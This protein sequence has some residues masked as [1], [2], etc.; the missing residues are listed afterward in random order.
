MKFYFKNDN[1]VDSDNEDESANTDLISVERNKVMFYSDV[2]PESCFKLIS[3]I[4][5]AK[6]YVAVQN[7]LSEFD[8]YTKIYLHICSDGGE[9]FPALAVIDIIQKSKISIITV[10]EGCVASAG[11]LIALAGKERYMRSNGYML[12]HELRSCSYG[13]YTV[14]KDEMKCNDILMKDM[15][16]YILKRCKKPLMQKKIDKILEHDIIWSGKKC[17]K[18][19]LVNKII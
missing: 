1:I 9:V 8:E 13:K 5:K 4:N 19:G 17:K 16:K 12:L 3:C 11:V 6:E 2:T 10:S 18:Y 15:K 14:M 7:A